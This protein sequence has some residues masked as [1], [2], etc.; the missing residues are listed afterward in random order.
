M[1]GQVV[2]RKEV[3]GSETVQINPNVNAG[4][5]VI[6]LFSGKRAQSEKLL[7]RLNYE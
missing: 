1:A 4:L 5:Y 6:T 2:L 3:M 7:M